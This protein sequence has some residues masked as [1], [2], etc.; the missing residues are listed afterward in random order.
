MKFG[1]FFINGKIN[2]FKLKKKLNLKRLITAKLLLIKCI[3]KIIN[4][5]SFQ[6]SHF[7]SLLLLLINVLRKKKNL[8]K[9][10]LIVNTKTQ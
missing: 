4:N 8:T 6:I 3:G 7:A 5:I 9:L 2:F 1:Y 10:A